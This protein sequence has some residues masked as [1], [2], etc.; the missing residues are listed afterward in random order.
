MDTIWIIIIDVL[1][2]FL[3]HKGAYGI[4]PI[5]RYF[6][7]TLPFTDFLI[8]NKAMEPNI[9]KQLLFVEFFSS[10]VTFIIING[11]CI[12]GAYFTTPSGFIVYGIVAF[13][14]IVVF[15]PSRDRYTHG[16][17]CV[18]QYLSKHSACINIENLKQ[19]MKS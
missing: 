12:L 13:L 7:F 19:A 4:F 2:A 6:T 17:Y 10:L 3:S 5:I 11:L 15:P 16:E 8:K 18:N 9:K 14:A 1:I